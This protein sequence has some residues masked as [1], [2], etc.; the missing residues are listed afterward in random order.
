MDKTL[1]IIV[2]DVAA[3][4]RLDAFL[5]SVVPDLTRSAVQRLIED[6]DVLL[7]GVVQK[8]SYKV[9]EGEKITVTIPPPA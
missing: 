2:T 4:T 6:G 7:D 9:S 1:H 8:S 5:A 3:G